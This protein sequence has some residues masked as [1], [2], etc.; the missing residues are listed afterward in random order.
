MKLRVSTFKN[1]GIFMSN[2]LFCH[3]YATKYVIMNGIKK[4]KSLFTVTIAWGIARSPRSGIFGS[5]LISD[6][7]AAIFLQQETIIKQKMRFCRLEH[8]I[9]KAACCWMIF[10]TRNNFAVLPLIAVNSEIGLV[11]HHT[12]VDGF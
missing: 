3:G 4:L 12:F 1:N 8:Y 5:N 6:K 10:E 11:I 2:I 9:N 7:Y